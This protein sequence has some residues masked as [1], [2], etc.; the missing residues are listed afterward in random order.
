LCLELHR[1]AGFE[2][3][4]YHRYDDEDLHFLAVERFDRVSDHSLPMESL[5]S[6]IAMGD[7]QFRETGD[8]LLEE[9]GD[10]I[11]RLAQVVKLAPDTS[12]QLYRRILM[13]LLTG[14]GDLHLDNIALLGGINDC[15]LAPV[16]D[17]SPM[18]A[19]PRHNLVSAI[20]FDP[21]EFTDHG[22]YFVAL[23]IHF[24]L[25][26]TR[27]AQCLEEALDATSSYAERVMALSRVPLKQR[28]QLVD[29]ANNER[30]L[31]KKH[32]KQ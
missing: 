5:F 3:P 14:N 18:R 23:G 20:P 27:V 1:E 2:V 13:A 19:W 31:L 9:L 12:E 7:H 30:V 21:G 4:G 26:R 24:G 25:S 10:V 16:Y 32:N 8:I 28:Q 17:P 29:I 6:V 11:E 15:R 22:A